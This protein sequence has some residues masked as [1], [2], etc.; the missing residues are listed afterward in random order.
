MLKSVNQGF[1]LLELMVVLTVLSILLVPAMGIKHSFYHYEKSVENREKLLEIKRALKTF[2]QINGYLPCPDTSGNGQQNR[3]SNKRCRDDQGQLPYLDLQAPARDVYGNPFLYAANTN[4]D[5]TDILEACTSASLFG[6]AG[7]VT[8]QWQQCNTTEKNFCKLSQCQHACDGTCKHHEKTRNK[9]PYIRTLTPPRGMT[10]A[11][12][13]ALRVCGNEATDCKNKTPLSKVDGNL[14]PVVIV[15]FGQGGDQTW[16][17]C[18]NAFESEQLNC[19]GKR[20]FHQK[21]L[22]DQFRHQLTWLTTPEVK[23]LINTHW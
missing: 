6:H 5:N 17:D 3:I 15:S 12:N 18:D 21:T 19:N 11:L 8:N 16:Q 2:I 1:T 22:S 14:L 9:P 13:G 7:E 20:Y 10:S 4:A 23:T